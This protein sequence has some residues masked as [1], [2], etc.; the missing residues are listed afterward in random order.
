MNP[1]EF[2]KSWRIVISGSFGISKC[3]Q[4]GVRL[5]NLVLQRHFFGC[6]FLTSGSNKGKIRNNFF[7]IFS[8]A[9]SR[10]TT[11]KIS[12]KNHEFLPRNG[13]N[14][15]RNL[16]NKVCFGF[17]WA[18][19]SGRA[20]SCDWLDSKQNNQS[21]ALFTFWRKYFSLWQKVPRFWF[22]ICEILPWT[23]FFVT[24]NTQCVRSRILLPLRF[25]R[26]IKFW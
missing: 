16:Q 2:S 8:F 14:C 17:G 21:E 10:F 15:S 22:V 12:L 7:G 20:R 11:A 19:R 6:F 23:I 18:G 9:G 4:N 26:E 1:N 25:L 3:L 13:E 5:N 24:K